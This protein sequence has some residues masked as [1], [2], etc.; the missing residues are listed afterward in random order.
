M[1]IPA[2]VFSPAY[3]ADIGPHV[4]PTGKYRGVRDALLAGGVPAAAFREP[5][6][7][8]RD[9]LELAHTR[10]YLDDL[11]ALRLTP[12][13]LA[14]ELPLTAEIARWF[15]LAVYGTVTAGNLAAGRGA[16]MHLGGGF[17]HAFADRAEGFCYLN[18]TAVGARAALGDAGTEPIAHRVSVVDLDVHQGNGTARIFQGD[19]RVFTF[20]IHQE[21]N[22]PVKE[23]GDLDIGVEDGMGD[24]AYLRELERGL[25]ISVRGRRPDLVYYLAGA[26]PYREDRL[27]G[28]GLTREGMRERD[29][30]VLDAALEVGARVVVLLAGGY[31]LDTRDTVGIHAATG[32]ELLRRW[33][34]NFPAPPP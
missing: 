31:A 18:D 12:A 9:L 32:E 7:G 13:T 2:F 21:N 6:P 5:E 14:S 4:F 34:G 26:D 19:D 25:G 15:E 10:A 8:S 20:S 22:Y 27:G 24:A 3:E 17:H 30:R 16:A 29:R 33:P 28:L 1:S 23:R 11:F